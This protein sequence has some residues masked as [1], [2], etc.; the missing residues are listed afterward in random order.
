MKV[1]SHNV[2]C[3]AKCVT[4]LVSHI[5]LMWMQYAHVFCVLSY[6]LDENLLLAVCLHIYIFSYQIYTII[7][8]GDVFVVCGTRCAHTRFKK[9]REI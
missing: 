9:P 8:V 5:F 4:E 3:F 6:S 7:L 2:L 1:H